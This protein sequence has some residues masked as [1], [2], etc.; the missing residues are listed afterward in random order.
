MSILALDTSALAAL[1]TK[2]VGAPVTVTTCDNPEH[3]GNASRPTNDRYIIR[4]NPCLLKRGNRK[5]LQFTF[6]HE[7]GHCVFNHPKI[8]GDS[9]W[10]KNKNLDFVDTYL[11]HERQADEFASYCVELFK[12]R[13]PNETFWG[14]FI[15][16][17]ITEI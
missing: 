11:Y 10:P 15:E 2:M 12:E 7:V 6:W 5:Y 17:F 8:P 16:P 9:D 4:L 13:H 1:A 3:L 14:M